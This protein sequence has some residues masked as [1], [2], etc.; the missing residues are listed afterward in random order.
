MTESSVNNAVAAQAIEQSC[1]YLCRRNRWALLLN[2]AC[3]N[4]GTDNI[5]ALNCKDGA[6]PPMLSD[7]P[8]RQ[9][10]EKELMVYLIRHGIRR[11]DLDTFMEQFAC[12]TLDATAPE[13]RIVPLFIHDGLGLPYHEMDC[14][15]KT[16]A[17]LS[18]KPHLDINDEYNLMIHLLRFL[19]SVQDGLF[20]FYDAPF[21]GLQSPE[22]MDDLADALRQNKVAPDRVDAFIADLLILHSMRLASGHYHET[23]LIA[24]PTEYIPWR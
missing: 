14:F 24:P 23:L 16:N 15:S 19:V 3:V 17:G 1:P 21:F 20:Q 9:L 11:S 8:A 12:F 5:Y 22:S 6:L 10:D 18:D 4:K 13:D 2:L 7:L